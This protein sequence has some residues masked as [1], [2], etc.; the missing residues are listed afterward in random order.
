MKLVTT[1]LLR[2]HQQRHGCKFVDFARICQY[3][4]MP[5]Q[6]IL[7]TKMR[8]LRRIDNVALRHWAL[9]LVE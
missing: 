5:S 1:L 6:H 9:L 2:G 8:P 7:M 4:K 3:P